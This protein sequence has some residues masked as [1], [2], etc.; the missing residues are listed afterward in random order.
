[1]FFSSCIW[2]PLITGKDIGIL[3]NNVGVAGAVKYFH[4]DSEE[5]MRNM[6]NVNICSMTMMTKMILPGMIRNKRGAI[7]NLSSICGIA[8]SPFMTM[9]SVSAHFTLKLFWNELLTICF[10]KNSHNFLTNQNT[11]SFLMSPAEVLTHY[12]LCFHKIFY[13]ACL[14]HRFL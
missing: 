2:K 14:I 9:V 1:M 5:N 10:L 8:P 11:C 6:I 12:Y 7:I 13:P 4:E 3:V